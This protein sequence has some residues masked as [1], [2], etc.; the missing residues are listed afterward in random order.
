MYTYIQQI[1]I[2]VHTSANMCVYLYVYVYLY[3]YIYTGVEEI[4]EIEKLIEV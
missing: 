2:C 3:M 1:F 4:V